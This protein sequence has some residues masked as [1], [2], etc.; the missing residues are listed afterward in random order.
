MI[1]PEE[2]KQRSEAKETANLLS[3]TA[4]SNQF[5]NFEDSGYGIILLYFFP[6]TILLHYHNTFS[7]HCK[8]Y[9]IL[10]INYAH[11]PGS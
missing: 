9:I 3:T 5:Q 6:D 4:F 2:I 8:N 1:S 11:Y 7:G 10:Y